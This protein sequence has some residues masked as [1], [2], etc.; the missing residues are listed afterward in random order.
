MQ[1]EFLLL[2]HTPIILDISVERGHP[3]GLEKV[4]E[5]QSVRSYSTV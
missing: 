1:K 5:L 2:E 3:T 4:A